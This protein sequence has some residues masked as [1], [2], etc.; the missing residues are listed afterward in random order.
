[1]NSLVTTSQRYELRF[2]GHVEL[3]YSTP[4]Y[5]DFSEDYNELI[6]SAER[7]YQELQ[8]NSDSFFYP[9]KFNQPMV[10]LYS[11]DEKTNINRLLRQSG[12]LVGKIIIYLDHY[13]NHSN[14]RDANCQGEGGNPLASLPSSI[15]GFPGGESWEEAELNRIDA[16]ML[17]DSGVESLGLMSI[18]IE[19][20]T[21]TTVAVKR[22]NESDECNEYARLLTRLKHANEVLRQDMPHSY[23]V[24]LLHPPIK[25][26]LKCMLTVLQQA[27]Q[28]IQS[29]DHLAP[30]HKSK[31]SHRKQ[32]R[33]IFI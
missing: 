7:Q 6:F 10:Y 31:E 14:E 30:V 12:T 21:Q 5:K 22:R 33:L 16:T 8:E 19:V 18:S 23:L 2:Q 25:S 29:N 24:R 3:T 17:G 9:D 20:S 11:T 15:V 13:G 32:K 4:T 27:A 1:M 28:P 26:T